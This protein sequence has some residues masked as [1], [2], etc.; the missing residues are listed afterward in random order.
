M[1]NLFRQSNTDISELPNTS[2]TTIIRELPDEK[3]V[4]MAVSAAMY[5]VANLYNDTD[6]KAIVSMMDAFY[7]EFKYEPLSVFIEA[8]NDFKTGKI[9]VF[10]RITPNQ[11]REAIQGKLEALAIKRENE[12]LDNKG[13][14]GDR[15]TITLREALAQIT[16]W[17]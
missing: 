12:H 2:L 13:H 5:S 6:P 8:I 4:K 1:T 9:K 11:M 16:T 3:E 15:S 7:D 17:K 14:L 10:G